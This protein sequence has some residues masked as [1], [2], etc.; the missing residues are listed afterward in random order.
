MLVPANLPELVLHIVHRIN[1]GQNSVRRSESRQ[2][3]L[4]MPFRPIQLIRVDV[5]MQATTGIPQVAPQDVSV[6]TNPR[7]QERLR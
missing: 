6:C 2:R 4:I 1:A 5:A 3:P 7:A